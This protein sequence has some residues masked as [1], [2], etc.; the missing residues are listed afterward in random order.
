MVLRRP[1]ETTG[2]IG[3]YWQNHAEWVDVETGGRADNMVEVFGDLH[4]GDQVG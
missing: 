2:P 1:I 3:H 4:D